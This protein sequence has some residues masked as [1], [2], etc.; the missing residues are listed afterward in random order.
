[1]NDASETQPQTELRAELGPTWLR[2]RHVP[3][4]SAGRALAAAMLA[5]SW[6]Q[7]HVSAARAQQPGA[8][9]A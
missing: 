4:P 2:A 9:R 6:T 7:L 3:A 8:A 5:V 1:M